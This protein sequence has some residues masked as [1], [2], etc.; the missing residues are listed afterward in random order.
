MGAFRSIK[1]GTVY[2]LAP[3]AIQGFGNTAGFDFY[4]QDI[5]GAGH[6]RLMEARNQLLGLAAQSKLLTGTRPNGQEDTPQYSV[7]IDQEKASALTLPL[8]AINNTLSTAWGSA[9][10]NAVSYTHLDVYKRQPSASLP[11]PTR[12]TPPRP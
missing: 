7:E 11:A 6:A 4:L 12:S 3:P 9:Y 5:A 10:V 2:A 8:A 1:D